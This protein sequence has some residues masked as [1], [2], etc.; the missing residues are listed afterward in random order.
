MEIIKNELNYLP[1]YEVDD[2]SD[3]GNNAILEDFNEIPH[4][5][6]CFVNEQYDICVLELNRNDR[7]YQYKKDSPL[8][9]M[10]FR[11]KYYIGNWNGKFMNVLD[12]RADEYEIDMLDKIR[13]NDVIYFTTQF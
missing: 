1:F 8:F 3:F 2:L 7:I 11:K 12:T 13:N 10:I 9:L 4:K 5:R 6:I